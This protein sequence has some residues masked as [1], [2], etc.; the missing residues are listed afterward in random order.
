[1]PVDGVLSYMRKKHRH[2][3]PDFDLETGRYHGEDGQF[4]SG[5]PRDYDPRADRFRAKDGEFKNRSHYHQAALGRDHT[6]GQR[7]HRERDRDRDDRRAFGFGTESPFAGV[8]DDFGAADM[9][10]EPFESGAVLDFSAGEVDDDL[11][12]FVEEQNER[13]GG[14]F[15]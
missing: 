4:V 11:S 9:D 8:D 15:F 6:D 10:E 1:M 14:L 12:E 13:T 7:G 2:R 5:P 3:G